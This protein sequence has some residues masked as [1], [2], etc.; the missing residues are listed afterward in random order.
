MIKI[1]ILHVI[2]RII[3][4]GEYAEYDMDKKFLRA[5][6]NE[7]NVVGQVIRL[8]NVYELCGLSIKLY[9]IEPQCS[10]IFV[11]MFKKNT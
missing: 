5:V 10:S 11:Y 1:L 8:C 9:R 3:S 2:P 6:E 7:D 4:Y